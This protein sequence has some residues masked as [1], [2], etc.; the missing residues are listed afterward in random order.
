MSK[1]TQNSSSENALNIHARNNIRTVFS[2]WSVPR[3]YK[4]GTK[5]VDSEICTEICENMTCAGGREIATFGAVTRKRLVR[6]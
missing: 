4:Q 5:S 3:C 2:V 1:G 6:H